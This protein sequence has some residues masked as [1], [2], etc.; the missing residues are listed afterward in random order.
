MAVETFGHWG[1]EAQ[2]VLSRL[3]SHLSISLSQPRAAVVADIYGRLNIILCHADMVGMLSDTIA[4]ETSLLSCVA[5]FTYLSEYL[6]SL[7]W[8]FLDSVAWAAAA[9]D[10]PASNNITGFSSEVMDT[11]NAA[12]LLKNQLGSLHQDVPNHIVP[13][14]HISTVLARNCMVAKVVKCTAWAQCT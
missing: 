1:R 10:T 5:V 12:V 14:Y 13:S 2:S 11:S 7:A 6:G 8:C 4:C 3:A 9:A